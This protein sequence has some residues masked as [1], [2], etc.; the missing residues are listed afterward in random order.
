MPSI[1]EQIRRK[2]D[3]ELNLNNE[4]E[5][6]STNGLDFL[7]APWIA[8]SGFVAFKIGTCHG[9][10]GSDEKNFQIL[11]IINDSPGNGHLQD[12][13]DWFENSCKRDKK[14]LMIMEVWNPFL[15]KHLLEKRGFE[16]V[17]T[18]YLLKSF[19]KIVANKAVI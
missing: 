7:C 13:F 19:D 15:K 11:S 14:G 3:K 12:V 2:M 8:G 10:Y 9:L 4:P 18:D 1:R 17:T 6:K 5:F 16:E